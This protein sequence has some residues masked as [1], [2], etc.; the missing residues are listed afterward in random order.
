MGAM[1]RPCYRYSICPV[2]SPG[3]ISDRP[4][5]CSGA[6]ALSLSQGMKVFLGLPLFHHAVREDRKSDL[7]A[8]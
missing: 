5:P 8:L 3:R 6:T 4:P 2:A 1:L 7:L